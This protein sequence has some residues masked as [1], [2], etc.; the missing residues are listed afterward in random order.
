MATNDLLPDNTAQKEALQPL[1]KADADGEAESE[2]PTKDFLDI[3]LGGKTDDTCLDCGNAHLPQRIVI[4]H[5]GT[6]MLPDG[7]IGKCSL[8]SLE[9]Q[10]SC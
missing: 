6:W 8:E 2:L 1:P 9:V 3:T 7:A 10:R 4:C 5:D